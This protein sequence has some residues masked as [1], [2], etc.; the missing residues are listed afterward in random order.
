MNTW[1]IT[2]EKGD[3]LTLKVEAICDI[4]EAFGFDKDDLSQVVRAVMIDD[5][6]FEESDNEVK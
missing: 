5:F 1:M 3:T 2:N 6:P 4:P